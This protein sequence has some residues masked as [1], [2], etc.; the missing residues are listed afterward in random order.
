MANIYDVAPPSWLERITRPPDPSKIGHDI[1]T[2][3]AGGANALMGGESFS[4]G[5]QDARMQQ[6]DPFWRMRLEQM[7]LNAQTRRLVQEGALA[8]IKSAA[9]AAEL[10]TKQ[11]NAEQEDATLLANTVNGLENQLDLANLPAPAFKT[12][13]YSLAF[14]KMQRDAASG[15]LAKNANHDAAQFD[16][17][18]G[19]L[20]KLDSG[21]A[22]SIAGMSRDKFGMPTVEAKQA[23]GLAMDAAKVRAQNIAEQA[24]QDALARGEVA[25]TTVT[26][27]KVTEKFAMPKPEK[28]DTMAVEPKTKTLPDGSVLTWMPGGKGI[29]IIRKGSGEPKPLTPNQ[30]MTISKGL[31]DKDPDKAIIISASKGT[32]LK[33]A[34]NAPAKAATPAPVVAAPVAR[35]PAITSKEQFDALPAGAKYIGKDGKLYQKP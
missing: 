33:Q 10:R 19:A 16:V 23:L 2:V 13:K 4:Q 27:D 20:Y 14:S 15:F 28:P 31:D 32:A 26:G 12:S 29:H 24:R 34:T 22:S 21:A 3:L 18:L 30:L 1:G 7:N 9:Q 17:Q 25:T 6:T 8:K 35:P 11:V 5:V